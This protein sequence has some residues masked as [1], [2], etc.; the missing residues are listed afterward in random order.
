VVLS[1]PAALELA[2]AGASGPL[3]APLGPGQAAA[4]A[5]NVDDP[6]IV[7]FKDQVPAVPD[8]PAGQAARAQAVLGV[9]APVLNELAATGARG[10]RSLRLLDAVTATVSAGEAQR[11]VSDPVVAEV[12]PDEPI[13]LPGAT[14][15]ALDRRAAMGPTGTAIVPSAALPPGTCPAGGNVQLNP[16][17]I[18][19][20][21]AA[22]QSRTGEVAQA[23]GY[24]GT[25]VKVGFIADGL[26]ID[27][28]DFIRTS[29]QHVFVDYQD[30][31][32]AGTAA[33][34][35]GGE[36]FLDASSIAAQGRMV[37]DVAPYAGLPGQCRIRIEG[38]APGASLVGLDV[39][40]PSGLAFSS[41]FLGAIDYAVTVDHVDVLNESFG[42]NPFP[43]EATADL[44]A[45][46]DDAAAAAGVTVTVSTGDAG[47]T[48]T[49]GSPATDPNVIAVGASTTFRAY[50]QTQVGGINLPGVTGWLPDNVSAVSSG[51]VDQTGRTLDLVAPGDLNW[52]LCTP[53]PALYADCT[54]FFGRPAA[55]QLAGGTSESAPLAAGVAALVI[56]AYAQAHGGQH[57]IPSVVKQILTSTADDIDAPGDQ[58]GAGLLDAFQGVL[59]AASYPGSSG[60][61]PGHTVL[62]GTDQLNVTGEPG[63]VHTVTEELTNNGPSATTLS[64]GSR[65]LGPATDVVTT[66]AQLSD[67]TGDLALVRFSV[68]PAQ[69][70]LGASIAFPGTPA[71]NIAQFS[72]VDPNGKFAA[73]DLPQG[74]ANFGN[75]QVA[76]PAPGRWTAIIFGAPAAEGGFVGTVTF[77]ATVAAWAPFATVKPSTVPLAPG[78]S[79]S[80]TVTVRVPETPGDTV[81]SILVGNSANAPAF[82]KTTT[83]PVTVRSLIPTAAP[84]TSFTGTLTGGNGRAVATGVSAD[85]ALDLATGTPVLNAQVTLPSAEPVLAELVDPVT[86]EAAS[87]SSS[88]LDAAHAGSSATPALQRGLEL[89]VLAPHPGRWVLVLDFFG[90][91]SGSSL[92]EPYTV[93]VD[94]IPPAISAPGLPDRAGTQ[95]AAGVPFTTTVSVRNDR[96]LPEEIFLDARRGQLATYPLVAAGLP[97]VT[98]PVADPTDLPAYLVPA[99]TTSI[100]AAASA[101]DPIR[102]DVS[103]VFGDPDVRAGPAGTLVEGSVVAHDVAS[104]LWV[105]APSEP[106]PD[107]A[108]GVAPERVHTAMWATTAVFDP[109]VTSPTGD[110]WLQAL[111]VDPHLVPQ[112]VAPGATVRIP[113]TITPRGPA[114]S[115]VAGTLSVSALSMIDGGL[116]TAGAGGVSPQGSDEAA[117][118]Y[119]Y[120]VG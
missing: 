34:T 50:A 107:G 118:A 27:N 68:P 99:H 57:P 21:H 2:S 53:R 1:A 104:G 37:Y 58:Q 72:L 15:P 23:L 70:R 44:I 103:W 61:S 119:R 42:S 49:I 55:V 87:T 13:R 24:T 65:Q 110:L 102:F 94:R 114:G 3:W 100:T 75:E 86:E 88:A 117:F 112:L 106:G 7:V 43:D 18:E 91:V 56:Q 116:S 47:V 51:G 79:A 85:Y 62:A 76:D 113:V 80:V 66:S 41:T 95:L 22:S 10:V 111:G 108:D 97:G 96:A 84:S 6:V 60:R 54:D 36:A 105:I 59:A 89:H 35:A 46:A 14:R 45:Q 26:D 11:L 31:S 81:G 120:T 40:G 33:P 17:A 19:S 5:T 30:F 93:T 101:P 98:V 77:G 64:I 109:A 48:N 69:A 63:S 52:A 73:F 115:V 78:L 71:N 12:V 90:V 9:Q 67:A 83:I 74:P 4:L 38:A 32:G 28:P 39:V 20:I 92:A 29:G 8:T 82:A 16:Q 25:G